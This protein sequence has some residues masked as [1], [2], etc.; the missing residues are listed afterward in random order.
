ML[1]V[2]YLLIVYFSGLPMGTQQ[3]I[4]IEKDG[5]RLTP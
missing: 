5:S 4:S 2:V 1:D 3:C